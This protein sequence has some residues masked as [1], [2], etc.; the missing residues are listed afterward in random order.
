MREGV[1]SLGGVLHEAKCIEAFIYYVGPNSRVPWAIA[2][3]VTMFVRDLY[4]RARKDWVTPR[5]KIEHIVR[6]STQQEAMG[7]RRHFPSH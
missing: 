4:P 3:P 6:Q 2:L 5:M 7:D 1:N